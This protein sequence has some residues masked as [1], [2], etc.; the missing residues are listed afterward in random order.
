MDSIFMLILN[1]VL[2]NKRYMTTL[3]PILFMVLLASALT[4]SRSA[5]AGLVVMLAVYF[6]LVFMFSR[7]GK[8]G[9]IMTLV[10]VVPLLFSILLFVAGEVG[11]LQWFDARMGYQH[12]DDQRFGHQ[13]I[14]LREGLEN[15]WGHGPGSSDESM[16]SHS[17][18][19]RLIYENGILALICFVLFNL[20]IL[21][22]G[23][24]L[25]MHRWQYQRFS[26]ALLSILTFFVLNGFTVDTIH[27]RH[28]F[29]YMGIFMG[30]NVL[31]EKTKRT[32]SQG[33]PLHLIQY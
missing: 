19:V 10:A 2:V 32:Q 23:F 8:V 13:E 22:I 18:Y 28:M 15:F 6:G 25:S 11:Y 17:T 4:L 21:S 12:Y 26:M 30:L 16:A 1:Y 9:V 5:W 14:L 24:K 7:T 20:Y 3:M 29:V 27:W 31:F 33:V